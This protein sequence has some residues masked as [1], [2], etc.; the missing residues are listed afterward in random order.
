[1]ATR[2]ST[3]HPVK[4]FSKFE[5]RFGV[6]SS[7]GDQAVAIGTRKNNTA[8]SNSVTL[9]IAHNDKAKK[10]I[11]RTRHTSVKIPRSS[12]VNEI[13]D[14]SDQK[15]ALTGQRGTSFPNSRNLQ[16]GQKNNQIII[17]W[18]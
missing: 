7:A 6:I 17:F 12:N 10:L 4:S 2:M 16:K 8:A 15:K 11:S 18:S 5:P 1:M 3:I 14:D 13:S 9:I